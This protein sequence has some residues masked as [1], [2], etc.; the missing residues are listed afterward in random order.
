MEWCTNTEN[1]IHAYK[2]GLNKHSDNAGRPKKAVGLYLND[3]SLYK[4][5]DSIAETSRHLQC[6]A[7]EIKHRC[8]SDSKKIKGYTLRY[9][10]K[11]EE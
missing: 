3:G 5:F 2:L 10:N 9:I 11:K 4:K 1:Q 8:N 7:D 6:S